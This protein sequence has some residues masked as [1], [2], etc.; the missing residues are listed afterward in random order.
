MSYAIR[1]G[2]QW[3][4]RLSVSSRSG[5][6][7]A[8]DAHAVP[9]VGADGVIRGLALVLHDASSEIS[10]EA[11]CENLNEKASK[12]PLTQL[13]NRAEFNRAHSQFVTTYLENEVPCSLIICDIDRFKHVN[14]TYGHQAGDEVI[15]SVARLLKSACQPGDLAAR[16]GG[17]EFVL[18]FAD[19]N[20][21]RAVRRAE[22]LRLAFASISQPALGGKSVTI[23]FGVT[24]IQP[25]DTPETM[26]RRADRA[27][28][29]AKEAGRNR[30]VQLGSGGDLAGS[31]S[32]VDR[33]GRRA[34]RD[35]LFE[36]HLVSEA[37]L[38]VCIEKLRGFVGDHHAE[39]ESVEGDRIRLRFGDAGGWSLRRMTDR[40][41]RL[42]MDLEFEE[43]AREQRPRDGVNRSG[44]ART[45][46]HM[47]ITP[48]KRRDRRREQLDER[49]RHLVSSFRSYLMATEAESDRDSGVLH[50]AKDLL[51]NWF[52]KQ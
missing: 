5:R 43:F 46:I 26:L 15:M 33:T 49:A 41:L 36:C 8:V 44:S 35:V 12:D 27:L 16:Y 22:E 51:N 10:L 52:R 1:T 14:D 29:N 28:M 6:Q 11:R 19:S 23:S 39:V 34:S 9:V 24:E 38:S 45:K 48:Q 40:P 47:V 3:L 37:P 17:E 18:L 4:R 31:A 50:K 2:V 7:V 20:C 21:A 30:V 42:L 13:A 32:V 25:G